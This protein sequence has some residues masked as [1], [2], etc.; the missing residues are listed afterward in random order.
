[1]DDNLIKISIDEYFNKLSSSASAPG[2][3]SASGLAGSA[4]VS[5]IMMV[6]G[7]INKKN[8]LPEKFYDLEYDKLKQIK[9]A[10]L[11]L[12]DKDAK[13]YSKFKKIKNKNSKEYNALLKDAICIPAEICKNCILL[14]GIINKL[15]LYVHGSLINDIDGALRF[16]ETAF[17]ISKNNIESNIAEIDNKDIICDDAEISYEGFLKEIEELKKEIN[18]KRSKT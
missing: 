18:Q 11:R 6:L 13:I 16:N 8:V 7:I 9:E 10:F 14:N 2:G 1:M 15:I 5:L 12:C 3:G 17:F 4:A